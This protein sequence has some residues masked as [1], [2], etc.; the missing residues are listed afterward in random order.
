MFLYDSPGNRNNFP[1]VHH[2]ELFATA[3]RFSLKTLRANLSGNLG[4]SG[5]CLQQKN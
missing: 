2:H 4:H 1:F 3:V 5:L